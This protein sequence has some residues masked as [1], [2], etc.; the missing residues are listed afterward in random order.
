MSDTQTTIEGNLTRDPEIRFMPDGTPKVSI[1]VAVNKSWI[2]RSTNERQEKVSF[3]DV[4]GWRELATNAEASLSKGD[5]V[6]VTGSLE[7]QT[8]EQDGVKRS[9]VVLV[10]QAM[11]PSLRWATATPYKVARDGST[12][13]APATVGAPA[14]GDEFAGEEPF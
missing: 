13:K 7:Q 1:G 10:A 14:T 2:D 9:K 5:R 6:I 12:A 11:G 3:F 4:E 8:W